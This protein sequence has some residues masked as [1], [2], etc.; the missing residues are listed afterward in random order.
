MLRVVGMWSW[1]RDCFESHCSSEREIWGTRRHGEMKQVAVAQSSCG[2]EE[3][4]Y[5]NPSLSWGSKTLRTLG[6]NTPLE[7]LGPSS[8]NFHKANPIGSIDS[9]VFKLNPTQSN[10]SRESLKEMLREVIDKV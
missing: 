5:P 10:V 8:H 4:M 9:Q 7:K 3:Q 2:K 6:L 1:E